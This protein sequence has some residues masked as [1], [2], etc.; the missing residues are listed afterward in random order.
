MI[1]RLS[2]DYVFARRINGAGGIIIPGSAKEK[3]QEGEAVTGAGARAEDGTISPLDVKAGDN[4]LLGKW[5]GTEAKR[6][7][8]GLLITKESGVLEIAG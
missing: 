3:A 4:V 5:P 8:A 6:D 1:F 2:H 7:D